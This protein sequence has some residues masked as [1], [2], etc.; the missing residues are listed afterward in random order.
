M[1]QLNNI[2]SIRQAIREKRMAGLR[3][4]LVPTM[5]NLHAGHISLV[6][7]ARELGDCV[8]VS[9]FVNPLQFGANED[10]DSYPR[11]LEDDIKKL[12]HEGVELVFAP[13][14]NEMYPNGQHQMTRVEV[15]YFNAI[16][17]GDSR[18][19]HFDGVTTVVC[20]LLNLVQPDAAVFGEKDF[21]QLFII[22]RMVADLSLPVDIVGAPI[23]REPDGLA[24]S[25]RNQ[26]LSSSERKLAAALS[27]VLHETR[28]KC[29]SAGRNPDT[30]Q[31]AKQQAS[32]VLA[33]I[34]FRL[35]YLELRD[36][37]N[38]MEPAA[39]SHELVLLAAAYLGNT[40]LI[41]NLC[42]SIEP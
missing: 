10:L 24:M 19:G 42:F 13:T 33:E 12:Q 1:R 23:V 34:G 25:S 35:D 39:D 37:G 22:R 21:Q 38:L 3:C 8:V 7:K 4:V 26:Y 41:D 20:K 14:A 9:I 27:R 17:C 40:R 6:R 2:A 15:P 28:D 31:A 11:T 29:Q 36:T 16:L 18:P 30:W 5:G 32:T